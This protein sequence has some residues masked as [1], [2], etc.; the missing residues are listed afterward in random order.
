[1]K[2]P[3][4]SHRVMALTACLLAA[5]TAGARDTGRSE[6]QQ[7]TAVPRS[8]LM[9]MVG[10]WDVQQRTW[11]SSSSAPMRH[12]DASAR[13][14]LVGGMFVEETMQ[15]E[16]G[17]KR[18]P[19]TRVAY[20]NY[21]AVTQRYETVSMD[22]RGPQM[23]YEKSY[24]HDGGTIRLLLEDDFVLSR[25][26]GKAEA[27]FKGRKEIE[28]GEDRQTV[29]LYWT[30]LMENAKEFLATEYIYTRKR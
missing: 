8:L 24:A 16:A 18:E 7:R 23:M 3:G 20:F 9:D 14:R 22:T 30:P 13:R 10:E 12:P 27:A 2:R 17:P 6:T 21:N 11:E 15:G 28:V 19:F 29:R 25:F 1:M 4:R 5:H 26:G